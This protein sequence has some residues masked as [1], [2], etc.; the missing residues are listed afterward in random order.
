MEPLLACRGW[1]AYGT[2]DEGQGLTPHRL[3][4]AGHSWVGRIVWETP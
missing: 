4:Q 1:R 3:G 2:S